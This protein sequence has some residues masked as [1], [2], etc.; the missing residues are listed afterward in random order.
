MYTSAGLLDI[1]ART[2]RSLGMLLDHLATLPAD[3]VAQSVDGFSYPTV[4]A[5]LHHLIGAE[6][7]WLGVLR[8]EIR[9]DDDAAEHETIDGLQR[10]RAEV[11]DAS[12][13]FLGAASD[14]ELSTARTITQF[15]GVE[16]DV[17]PAHVLL[18]TQTHV[19]QHHGE[20]ASMLRLLGQRF[21]QRLDFPLAP[22]L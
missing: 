15:N 8:G 10:M 22:S 5:Q 9:V 18:R 7:Y 21:P 20:I 6:R 3:V 4:V 1:H 2:H 12:A 16:A 19:Y 14:D 17:V 11:F 13:A